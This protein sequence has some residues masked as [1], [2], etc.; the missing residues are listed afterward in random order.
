MLTGIKD[1]GKFSVTLLATVASSSMPY[2]AMPN[3]ERHLFGDIYFC[4]SFLRE[5]FFPEGPVTALHLHWIITC[6]HL[7]CKQSLKWKHLV[8]AF[9]V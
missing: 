9:P 8:L 3:T 1:S 5:K 4:I 7:G 2:M 6:L